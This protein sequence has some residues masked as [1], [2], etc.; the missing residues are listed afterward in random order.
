MS[1]DQVVAS[2]EVAAVVPVEPVVVEVKPVELAADVSK[3]APVEGDKPVE[4]KPE[5]HEETRQNRIQKRIDR[6]TREKYE[7][8]AEAKALRMIMEQSQPKPETSDKPTRAQ[9]ADDDAFVEALTDWKLD[10]REKTVAQT[11]D[12]ETQSQRAAE[13]NKRA[14]MARSEYPDFDDAIEEA[15][16]VPLHRAAS[17][18][19]IESD[20]SA[21]MQYYLAK[22]PEEAAAT[23]K[24]SPEGAA[25]HIGRIEAAVIAEKATRA[26]R[27]ADLKKVSK[28]PAPIVP[29]KPVGGD[30]HID[31]YDPKTDINRFMYERNKQLAGK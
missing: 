23:V 28:A 6:L 1:E 9:Y 31:I 22:H 12:Q 21:D 19:I 2:G 10:Q 8:M 20:V 29:V 16:D 17:R 5:D 7:A 4:P 14:D 24:M 26:S 3:D 18:A 15:Q 13:W 25:R 27:K 11:R 30:A